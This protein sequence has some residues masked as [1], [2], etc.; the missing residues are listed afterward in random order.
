MSTLH[1]LLASYAV[2][3]QLWLTPEAR[4]RAADPLIAAFEDT[5]LVN[6]RPLSGL[7]NLDGPAVVVIAAN[8]LQG[9]REGDLRELVRRAH[10]GRAVML[11]GTSDRD[12]LM[13]AIN[14]WGVI[15]VV[16][17]DDPPEAI[18]SAVRAA[19]QNLKREV[20]LESAID[21][22]DIETTML[23]SA[24]DHLDAGRAAALERT[25]G[26][27]SNTLSNGLARALNR[28]AGVV[29][30]LA[31]ADEGLSVA[32]EAIEALTAMVEQA[33]VR[34]I[35]RAAELPHAPEDLDAIIRGF[36]AIW[37][38]QHGEPLGGHVGTGA[39]AFVDPLAL[40]GTLLA[41][42]TRQSG[43]QPTR[44]DA[45][46]SGDRAIVDIE[47]SLPL[48][49]TDAT[50]RAAEVDFLDVSTESNRLRIAISLPDSDHG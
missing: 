44:V 4:K 12:T 21:D 28:E 15:R 10:P 18:V 14:E 19:S 36:C 30:D 20:A 46:R 50:M 3:L 8:E 24:I 27:A 9:R 7:A 42:C 1:E 6:T 5:A 17:A 31:Q 43:A 37:A 25:E 26:H 40:T 2:P 23:A 35:E 29:R 48:E 34:A 41:V 16:G 33:G 13:T 22:L 38:A 39:R 11:G 32:I 45:H 47:F 49:S